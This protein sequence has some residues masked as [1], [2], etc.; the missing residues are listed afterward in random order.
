V[1][2]SSGIC[3]LSHARKHTPSRAGERALAFT[4]LYSSR[5]DERRVLISPPNFFT[6]A[7]WQTKHH[8]P[9]AGCSANGSSYSACR[10][11]ES[12]FSCSFIYVRLAIHRNPGGNLRPYCSCENSQVWRRA[13]G[14]GI[15]TAGLV[16]G[17]IA[18]VLGIMGI[19]LLVSMI[20]SDRE[21]L[22]DFPLSERNRV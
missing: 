15:A 7:R 22:N 20:Q 11:L 6:T 17:Y 1:S 9:R 19:P 14:R 21:R 4:N 12:H 10:D 2:F 13:R 3:F 8:R 5:T 16:L 18:L